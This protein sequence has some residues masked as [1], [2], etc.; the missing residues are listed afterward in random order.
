[1][2]NAMR[3]QS[4]KITQLEK[5]NEERKTKE[6]TQQQTDDNTPILGTR[7][8]LTAGP[9]GVSPQPYTNGLSAQ[10]TGYG[11]F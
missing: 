11:R 6:V 4:N 9:G 10:N 3:H 8:M 5:D 2:I 1:M 7:L